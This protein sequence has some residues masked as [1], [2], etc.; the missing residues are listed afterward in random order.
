MVPPTPLASLSSLADRFATIINHRQGPYLT[1]GNHSYTNSRVF[2]VEIHFWIFYSVVFEFLY[3]QSDR[4]FHPRNARPPR[5]IALAAVLTLSPILSSRMSP[6][7]LEPPVIPC[8]TSPG[9]GLLRVCDRP[10]VEGAR[11]FARALDF[12]RGAGASRGIATVCLAWPPG[13]GGCRPL[14]SQGS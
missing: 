14:V 10:L 11:D 12:G 4:I 13:D 6:E 5:M 2:S 9:V 8:W 1:P 3:F 7:L